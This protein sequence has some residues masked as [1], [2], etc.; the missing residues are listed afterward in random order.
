MFW[1][2][3]SYVEYSTTHVGFSTLRRKSVFLHRIKISCF[4]PGHNDHSNHHDIIMI[5]CLIMMIVQWTTHWANTL[6][7]WIQQY[8]YQCSMHL[9]FLPILIILYSAIWYTVPCFTVFF[10][11]QACSIQNLKILIWNSSTFLSCR[12]HFSSLCILKLVQT[13]GLNLKWMDAGQVI[14]KLTVL[15]ID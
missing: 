15:A 7:P 9:S 8:W 14:L 1:S 13:I 6:V 4:W 12:Q 10:C 11:V 2:E 3:H 5:T